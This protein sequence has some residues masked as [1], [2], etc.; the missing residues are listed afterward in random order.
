MA[1]R[2]PLQNGFRTARGKVTEVVGNLSD[3]GGTTGRVI[4]AG[5]K[6]ITGVVNV[7]TRISGAAIDRTTRFIGL[8][9]Y[10]KELEAALDEATRVIATQEARIARL[11]EELG[12][13]TP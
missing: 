3:K 13:R 10:R 9:R 12:G 11:E 8:D 2:K 5:V 7:T 6:G 1:G 4:D